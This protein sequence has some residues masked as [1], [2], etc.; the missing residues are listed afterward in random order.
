MERNSDRDGKK[1]HRLC[2]CRLL[3]EEAFFMPQLSDNKI[4]IGFIGAGTVGT[5]LA[6]RLSESGYNITAVSD[7]NPVA[8]ARFTSLIKNSRGFSDNQELANRTDF[9][10]ITTIDDMIPKVAAQ[11]FWQAGQAVVHC[12]GADSTD[13]LEPAK[14]AGARV[15]CFH[16]LQTFAGIRKAIDNIPG[17]TFTLE[18]EEPLLS[19]L[20]KMASDLKGNWVVL[21]A[22]DKP[23]Y[24]AAAVIVSNYLVTL[25]KMST[26]LWQTFGVP[27]KQAVNRAF[28]LAKRHSQ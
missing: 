11:V 27:Q 28:A 19:I 26:D 2:L 25:V 1:G 20:K 13:I 10:F 24:H 23:A 8:I 4:K 7:C 18:A 3:S 12:S 9:V 22:G 15:G 14:K 21:K 5:A 17:S 6:S 16:P